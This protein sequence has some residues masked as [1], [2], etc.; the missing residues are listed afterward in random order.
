MNLV[1][2]RVLQI[3]IEAAS[4][5]DGA[6]ELPSLN[7]LVRFRSMT[8]LTVLLSQ[9]DNEPSLTGKLFTHVYDELRKIAASK[10]SEESGENTLQAT[11][12][13]HEAFI[14]LVDTSRPLDWESRGHFF[15]AAAEAT[16]PPQ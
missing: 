15:G 2:P 16:S 6:L 14:R 5:S 10:I 13:V 8:D 7:V 12:L 11:S 4:K 1:T 3:R 9:I